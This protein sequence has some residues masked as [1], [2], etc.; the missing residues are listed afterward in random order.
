M[1]QVGYQESANHQNPVDLLLHGFGANA[2][3]Q[4]GKHLQ[5]FISRFNVYVPDLLFFGYVHRSCQG[6]EGTDPGYTSRSK[7]F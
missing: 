5:M 7:S 2:M 1:A 6:E 3:W 4:Y